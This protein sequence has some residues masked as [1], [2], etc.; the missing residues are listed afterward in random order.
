[1]NINTIKRETMDYAYITQNSLGWNK[2][3]NRK[4]ARPFKHPL[5]KPCCS[6]EPRRL[7]LQMRIKLMIDVNI[8]MKEIKK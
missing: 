8:K 1:M 7:V 3:R 5:R 6:H 2:M 4:A